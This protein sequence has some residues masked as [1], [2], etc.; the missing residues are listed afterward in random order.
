[1]I[2]LYEA[3]KGTKIYME[4]DTN[5]I[6]DHM[7]RLFAYCYLEN[8]ANTLLYLGAMTKLKKYKDGFKIKE[9]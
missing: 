6:F 8:D 2:K 7:D 1:M 9:D 4:N 3:T 5:I